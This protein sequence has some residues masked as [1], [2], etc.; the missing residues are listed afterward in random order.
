[1]RITGGFSG[2]FFTPAAAPVNFGVEVKTMNVSE[3]LRCCFRFWQPS[4]AR[5]ITIYFV[6]FGLVVFG[7]TAVLYALSS[8]KHFTETTARL[9]RSQVMQLEGGN[10]PDF[11]WRRLDRPFSGLDGLFRTLASLSASFYSVSQIALYAGSPDGGSWDEL[12]F[13]DSRTLRRREAADP[14]LSRLRAHG[15][16]K[17]VRAML[18]RFNAG[19]DSEAFVAGGMPSVFRTKDAMSMFVDI[20]GPNDARRYVMKLTAGSEGV[21]GML[22][23]QMTS[24]FIL[25]LV[26]LLISRI[27]G[28]Y[29]ARKISR[30]IETLS[31]LAA[32]VA[33]GDLSLKAEVASADEIGLLARNFNTMIDGLREWQRVRV[34]EFEM[35]KGREIQLE[36]LPRQLP[37]PANWEICA[38]FDPAGQVSGD[39]YDAFILPDGRLGL[40]IADVCDKGVGSAL[41]MALFRS[42]IRV[43]SQQAVESRR[44]AGGASAESG[45]VDGLKAVA[46]TNRYIAGNH[47][48]ECMFATLFYGVVDLQSGVMH[49]INAG[50]EPLY[51]KGGAGIK[52]VIGRTGPAVGMLADSDYRIGAFRLERGDILVGYTD[53][54]TDARSPQDELFTRSRLRAIVEQ[55]L[56]SASGLLEHI[57]SA[58]FEFIAEAPRQDDITL[59]ALQRTGP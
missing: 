32:D 48:E 38:C 55:P 13:D 7:V 11:I 18:G 54:V 10:E 33:R 26:A 2:S 27:L 15:P 34:I 14:A 12:F 46:L 53:G 6:L 39:F 41:Y 21:S 45:P 4:L 24:F 22:R 37:Q 9:I 29:F 52:A 16:P 28:Y 19:A 43:F 40:V 35:A 59:L 57:R 36:F 31:A 1:M 3:H 47:D 20:T 23:R 25:L 44:P 58:V 49:Y 8:H 30:P 51:V 17:M 50:H 5:R 42:L 56:Q